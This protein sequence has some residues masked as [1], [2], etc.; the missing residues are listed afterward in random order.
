MLPMS[1]AA[2][3]AK[4]TLRR[5]AAAQLEPTPEN[6][7]R[8]WIQEGGSAAT[9]PAAQ[10]QPAL[11]GAW[12]AL[13]ERVVRGV[14][15][16]SR[17]WTPARRKE[18]LQRVLAGNR[19]DLQRLHE[20][21]AQ[22]MARW[23]GDSDGEFVETASDE[24]GETQAPATAETAA[25]PGLGAGDG[26]CVGDWRAL[27][28]S[29]QATVQAALPA[30]EARARALADRLAQLARRI[31]AE[32]AD[33][34]AVAAVEQACVQARRLFGQRH[35]LLD[36]L[37]G[38]ARELAAGLTELAEDDSWA[39]GQA[40]AL[41]ERLGGD[42]PEGAVPSV[43]G[44]RA[45]S[46]LL[47]RTR[48]QQQRLKGERDSARQA[49]KTLV[50]NLIAELGD[51]GGQTGRFS[52][53]LDRYAQDI[54]QADSLDGLAGLVRDMVQQSRAVQVEVASASTR[55]HAGQAEA[56]QLSTRVRELESELRRLADEVSTDALTQV[57]NRRGLEQAFT[58][59]CARHQRDGDT[60]AVALIDID[61]FKKLNDS[62]GH[63][64]GDAALRT[65]AARVRTA[66]RPVDHVARFGGEEFV[67]LLPATEIEASRQTLNR[68]QRELSA[69]LFM[70]EGR[71]V[72]V[73]FSA[74]VTA[75]RAGES[76]EAAIERAD[77]ALYEAKRTG[78]NRT[79]VA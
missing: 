10:D 40:M 34:A 24:F 18:S 8:A 66:L 12:A 73:T 27:S 48:R 21:L 74:G 46:E 31:D 3:F 29:L 65:L 20:R 76:L 47:A 71:E 75:W 58:A 6:Y 64:A 55:L 22:L 42:A 9:A 49:L 43:R 14:E 30:D 54:E 72:F 59:E 5:L 69:S 52:D 28:A 17:Q 62:L 41:Q 15:R 57:A 19:T 26:D 23:E 25:Q 70:H 39:R 13:I 44:V 1:T 60:L 2:Q 4:A 36:E 11:A 63:A 68:L 35:H 53:R 50:L 56:E 67:L 16:G 37:T 32:G 61:N 77:E 38:L 45:A 78:K 33:A 7:A 51:L 79:C